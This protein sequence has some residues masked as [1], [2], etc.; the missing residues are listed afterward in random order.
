[1]LRI[2]C[3]AP[4]GETG[5]VRVEGRITGEYVP[6]LSRAVTQALSGA[7]R[8]VLDMADVTFI[9]QA[10][11]ALLRR[12]RRQGVELVECSSFISTLVNGAAQ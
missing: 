4:S 12:L 9:D 6:E 7:P 1:L 8:V 10:G 5:T 11:V 3:T 2:T